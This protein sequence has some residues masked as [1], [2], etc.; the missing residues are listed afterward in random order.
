LLGDVPASALRD[1]TID[2]RELWG[3][4]AG[5]L[6]EQLHVTCG[7]QATADV[8]QG[9]VAARMAGFQPDPV[10]ETVVALL[11][12]GDPAPVAALAAAM[13]L[14]ERQLRRRVTKA[15][16]YPPKTLEGILRF[17]HAITHGRGNPDRRRPPLAEVAVAAGYAD[18]S[19]L[20]REVRRLAGLTPRALLG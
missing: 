2:M 17:R 11:G 15:V 8:L 13:G 7:V 18:Q 1:T 19:H 9:A 10:V 3:A 16:G 14:S 4:P 20:T 12:G 5:Q 6:V